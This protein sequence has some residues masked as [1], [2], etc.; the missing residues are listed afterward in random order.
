M[1]GAEN[2][3]TAADTTDSYEIHSSS[4]KKKQNYF[5]APSGELVIRKTKNRKMRKQASFWQRLIF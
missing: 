3:F 4:L 1:H 5:H 2:G